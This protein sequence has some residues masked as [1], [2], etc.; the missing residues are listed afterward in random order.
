MPYRCTG[1]DAGRT[2]KSRIVEPLARV[3]VFFFVLLCFSADLGADQ[4]SVRAQN[5]HG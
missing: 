2:K 3:C 1:T 4:S 5:D